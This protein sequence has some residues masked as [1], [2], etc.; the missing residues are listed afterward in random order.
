VLQELETA[1][2]LLQSLETT[3]L[4]ASRL[5]ARPHASGMEDRT[6]ALAI[7]IAEQREVVSKYERMVKRSCIPVK[8]FVDSISDTRLNVIMY[9]RFICGY[10]WQSV[11]AIVGSSTEAV[12]SLVYRFFRSTT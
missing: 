1:R 4:T 12:K 9:L 8:H 6:A 3:A 5:D 7:K 10:D 2:D 11:A